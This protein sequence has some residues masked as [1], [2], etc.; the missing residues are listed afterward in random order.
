MYDFEARRT[1][2]SSEEQRYVSELT[3]LSFI[4]TGSESWCGIVGG[5]WV[6]DPET[7][8]DIDIFIPEWVADNKEIPACFVKQT[9]ENG[10]VSE[11]EYE[12]DFAICGHYRFG[13]INLVVVTNMYWPAYI[14][15]IA[16]MQRHP[17]KYRDRPAR[18]AMHAAMRDTVT[19]M[20]QDGKWLDT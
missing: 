18:V 19:K 10:N 11:L 20:V 17:D 14:S 1:R 4:L 3:G 16:E 12:T 2:L 6:I 5:S 7:A 15:A 8:K 9:N 13:M